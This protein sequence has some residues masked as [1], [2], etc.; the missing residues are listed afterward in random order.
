VGRV[1]ISLA[2]LTPS[3]LGPKPG[4]GFPTSYHVVVLFLCSMS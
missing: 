3:N 1:V 2:S 4:P